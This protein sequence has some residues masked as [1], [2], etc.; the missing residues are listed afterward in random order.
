[1]GWEG[2][3][4][5]ASQEAAQGQWWQRGRALSALWFGVRG[6][7]WWGGARPSFCPPALPAS[8]QGLS[9]STPS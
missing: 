5:Q 9:P 6:L 7:G 8:R 4:G 1:M 2:R 3:G